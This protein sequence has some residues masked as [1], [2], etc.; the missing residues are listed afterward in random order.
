MDM[1]LEPTFLGTGA[2]ELYPNP[3]CGCETC[4]RARRNRETRLRACFLLDETMMVD[5]G[6]DVSAASQHYGV[7]LYD[8]EHVLITHTH[9]DHFNS[10]TFS[11]LTM[12][13][14]KHPIHFYLSA[15]GLAWVERVIEAER[16]IT[17][18][19]GGMLAGLQKNGK[20]VFHAV[21]P[22]RTYDIGGK[23]VTPLKTVHRGYG[24]GETAQNDIIEWDRGAW[25]YAADTS[26]YG[27]E[28]LVFL[29]AWAKTHGALDTMI[30]EGTFGSRR[31]PKDSGHMDVYQLAQQFADLRRAA[32]L[33][34][35]TRVFITHINQVQDFSHA[36]YQNFLNLHGGA[37]V[38]VAHDGMRI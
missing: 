20:V 26:L 4:E 37:N 35:H 25:L 34:A 21:D 13:N 10:A 15:A 38:T 1:K 30:F 3:F 28:N 18:S 36:E 24:E 6:P 17:G 9:E 23:R 19:F 14:M 12:T 5:F 29:A 22:Y 7:P 2:A 16:G 8:V 11:V 31:L 33:D 27:E 32:A